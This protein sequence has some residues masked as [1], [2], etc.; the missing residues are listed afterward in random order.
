MQNTRRAFVTSIAT[1]TAGGIGFGL[2]SD[3]T[4]AQSDLELTNFTIP[5]TDT[6]V[7]EPVSS[8]RLNV[9]A[10]YSIQADA[11]PTRVIL[12]LKGKHTEEFQ[13][14]AATELSGLQNN[15]SGSEVFESNLLDLSELTAPDLSPTDTGE[16]KTV[17]LSIKLVLTVKKDSNVMSE[18]SVTEDVTINVTKQTASADIQIGG[19]GSVEIN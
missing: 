10:D 2:A 17:D 4:Q 15:M 14:L 9:T 18:N 3:K 7:S 11:Q 1:I 13:Q 12:R 19:S 16:T 6:T 5:D 8:A